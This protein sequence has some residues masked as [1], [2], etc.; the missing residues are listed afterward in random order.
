MPW[1]GSV[2]QFLTMR[3]EHGRVT[4]GDLPSRMSKLKIVGDNLTEEERASSLLES[5]Q[6]MEEEV[7]FE[8]FLRV[9]S[10]LWCSF[11]C[12][13]PPFWDLGLMLPLISNGLLCFIESIVEWIHGDEDYKS[14]ML[15][16]KPCG[17]NCRWVLR[18]SSRFLLFFLDPCSYFIWGCLLMSNPPWEWIHGDE[19][20]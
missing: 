8:L 18:K 6:N 5:Y 4:V 11:C 10:Q 17:W 14:F 7:D 2:W 16:I 13:T 1:N 12:K 3:K 15:F 19:D 20:F 9:F